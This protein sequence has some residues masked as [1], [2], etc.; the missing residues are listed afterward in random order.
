MKKLPIFTEPRVVYL[1]LVKDDEILHFQTIAHGVQEAIKNVDNHHGWTTK[2]DVDV[3]LNAW[4]TH[5]L[6]DAQSSILI[7]GGEFIPSKRD[8]D[9]PDALKAIKTCEEVS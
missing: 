1:T 3:T 4:G 7:G 6:P 2:G 5:T 9:H 8:K